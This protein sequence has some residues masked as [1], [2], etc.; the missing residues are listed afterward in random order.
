EN[1]AM[2]REIDISDQTDFTLALSFGRTQ[3]EAA[4]QARASLLEGFDS[5]KKAYIDGWQAWQGSLRD[6]KGKKFRNS[7]AVLRMQEAK[8]FP[9][10]IIASLSIPWGQSK[11][12]S[13][14]GG[15]HLVWPRDLVESAGGFLALQTPND[16]LRNVNYL[17]STQTADGNGR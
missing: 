2:Q 6:V 4:N 13:D 10:G 15:Y 14:K 3:A 17:M 1:I 12:D 7:A 5:A 9:G 11:G 8:K 16:E